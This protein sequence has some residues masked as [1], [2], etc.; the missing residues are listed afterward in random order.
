MNTSTVLCNCSMVALFFFFFFI[1]LCWFFMYNVYPSGI[2][3]MAN[4]ICFN[5]RFS[6]YSTLG[7]NQLKVNSFFWSNNIPCAQLLYK[8]SLHV[9]RE[10]REQRSNGK[11]FLKRLSCKWMILTPLYAYQNWW[12]FWLIWKV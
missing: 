2:V 6:M 3:W 12:E 11:N 10:D 7:M 5:I 9:L 8:I 1:L 4:N